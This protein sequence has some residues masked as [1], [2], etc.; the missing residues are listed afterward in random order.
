MTQAII[1]RTIIFI[2]LFFLFSGTANAFSSKS[3][4]EKKSIDISAIST[5]IKHTKPG[6][7]P[8]MNIPDANMKAGSHKTHLAKIDELG[9]IHRF[10]R[11]RVKKA[12]K[13]HGKMW[14]F[15]IAVVVC[16]HIALLIH[17]FLHLS[18]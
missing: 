4:S 10:H 13:Y 1:F 17:A 18:H 14:F 11:E 15:A 7:A 5:D 16:C 12:K 8:G 6:A 3:E 9:K 2:S